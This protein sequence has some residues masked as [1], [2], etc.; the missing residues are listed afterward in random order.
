M[1]K[2]RRQFSN[3][4][5][6]PFALFVLF[7][8]NLKSWYHWRLMN[9]TCNH[10]KVINSDSIFLPFSIEIAIKMFLRQ[11]DLRVFFWPS[12]SI[13]QFLEKTMILAMQ[14]TVHTVFD[15]LLAFMKTSK[16]FLLKTLVF[17]TKGGGRRRP[18]DWMKLVKMKLK[19]FLFHENVDEFW[20]T[21]RVEHFNKYI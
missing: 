5:S 3:H 10:S 14:L 15:L 1:L 2:Y 13:N 17:L 16:I 19:G 4:F 20:L 6:I 9:H 7:L 21:L 11:F 12:I 8:H 18:A